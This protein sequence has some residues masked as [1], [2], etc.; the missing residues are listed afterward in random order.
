MAL[1]LLSRGH[2]Q[3][4]QTRY[5][6]VSKVEILFSMVSHYS[7]M[8]DRI[9][10]YNEKGVPKGNNNYFVPHLVYEP[11]VT[12]YNPYNQN[13]SFFR[14]RI[15]I[16]DPPVGFT[17]KKNGAYLRSDFAN[18]TFHNLGRFQINHELNPDA[19]KSFTMLLTEL[20]PNLQPGGLV[21]LRPGESKTF[22]AW[23]ENDW[24]W[25]RETAGSFT[26]R[27]F[28][29]WNANDELTNRDYRTGNAFG[30]EAVPST[31]PFLSANNAG[32]QTDGLSL[33][34]GRPIDTRYDF[35]I[36]NNWSGNYVA[37]KFGDVI[38]VQ[39][40]SMRTSPTTIFPEFQVDVMKG[41]STDPTADL[42]KA[43][44]MSLTGIIQNDAQP[45]IT[46]SFTAGS[47]LQG[48]TDRTSG[49]KMPFASVTMLAKTSALRQNRFYTQLG[50]AP[51]YTT[52]ND[53]YELHFKEVTDLDGAKALAS[54]APLGAAPEITGVTRIGNILYIDFTGRPAIPGQI[55]WKVRGSSNLSFIVPDNLDSVSTVMTGQ[56]AN[57]IYKAAID[58]SA[59]GERY[60]VR[61]EE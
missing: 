26:P 22:S 16:S 38:E 10:F 23:T 60:F 56:S 20:R 3:T 18:G 57:G 41:Q 15:K 54:D 12:L 51:P 4:S 61:I 39:A 5:P 6:V 30:F 59:L 50:A 24:T 34:G 2:A 47:I 8:G 52:F 17:F 46:R 25:G 43:F 27:S 21:T 7:H 53:L 32:F 9:A 58:I 37:T 42:V 13:L 31:T 44:P 28:F 45:V 49:G 35:E 40:K 48:P 29:D 1:A 55:N 14:S 33:S 36:A 11:L 19:R